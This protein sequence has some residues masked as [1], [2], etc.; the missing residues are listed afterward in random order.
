LNNSIRARACKDK[1]ISN[2]EIS[3]KTEE[4]RGYNRHAWILESLN[5]ENAINASPQFKPL[6]IH[7]HSQ[8]NVSVHTV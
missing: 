3:I 7:F 6:V 4:M 5:S 1:T 2:C 8:S